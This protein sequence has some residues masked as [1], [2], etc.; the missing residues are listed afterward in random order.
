MKSDKKHTFKK[1]RIPNLYRR[2]TTFYARTNVRGKT[3]WRNLKTTNLEVAQRKLPEVLRQMR[4]VGSGGAR[5]V[6]TV[7]KAL[8][9]VMEEIASSR[10]LSE[11]SRTNYYPGTYKTIL[12]TGDWLDLPLNRV[13]DRHYERWCNAHRE[14]YVASRT[15]VGALSWRYQDGKWKEIEFVV[16]RPGDEIGESL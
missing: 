10:A 3:C 6:P 9:V 8:E 15:K 12:R 1:T 16:I 2:G 14:Q 7:R 4:S 11:A 5:D 13:E